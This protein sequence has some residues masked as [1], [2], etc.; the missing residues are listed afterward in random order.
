MDMN[1]NVYAEAQSLHQDRVFGKNRLHCIGSAATV[2]CDTLTLQSP[3][4]RAANPASASSR[5]FLAA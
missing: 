5:C 2:I 3:A 1:V 4:P